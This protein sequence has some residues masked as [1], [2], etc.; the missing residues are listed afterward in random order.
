MKTPVLLLLSVACLSSGCMTGQTAKAIKALG[1][2]PASFHVTVQS[3]WGRVDV[4]RTNPGTNTLPH[5]IG[6]DGSIT[7]KP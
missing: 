6:T 2:D 4:S 3:P 1:N 5:I 7:V